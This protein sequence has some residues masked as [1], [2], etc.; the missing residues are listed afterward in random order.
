MGAWSRKAIKCG[1]ERSMYAS[2]ALDRVGGLHGCD[3][4][5]QGTRDAG[6]EGEYTPA[7]AQ[8]GQSGL[9]VWAL[10]GRIR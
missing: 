8:K 7:M 10:I 9:G 4:V 6:V 3:T 5:V 1:V 2:L